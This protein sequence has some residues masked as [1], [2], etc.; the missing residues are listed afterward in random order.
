MLPATEGINMTIRLI[1]PLLFLLV[2]GC[3]TEDEHAVASQIACNFKESYVF[4]ETKAEGNDEINGFIFDSEGITFRVH[5]VQYAKSFNEIKSI[6]IEPMNAVVT[7]DVFNDKESYTENVGIVQQECW[8]QIKRIV[9][10]KAK[11][12]EKGKE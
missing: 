2:G 4:L 11:L 8:G 10:G 9:A 7:I 1:A 6:N 12:V 5:P 3:M